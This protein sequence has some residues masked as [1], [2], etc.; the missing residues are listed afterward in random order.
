M[1]NFCCD[2][3]KWRYET[4]PR[5]G[6]NVRVANLLVDNKLEEVSF[7]ITEGYSEEFDGVKYCKINYCPFCGSNLSKTYK[8]EN[9]IVNSKIE[10]FARI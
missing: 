7:F 10:D 5:M 3:F 4:N 8:N 2:D 9:A 1:I 6:L